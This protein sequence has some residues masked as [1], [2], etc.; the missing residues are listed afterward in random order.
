MIS[1]VDAEYHADAARIRDS[2]YAQVLNPVRWQACVE[3]LIEDGCETFWEIGPNRVLKGLM[4]RINRTV[5]TINVS[6]VSDLE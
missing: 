3:R 4:R 2:L 6:S 1:N 5:K